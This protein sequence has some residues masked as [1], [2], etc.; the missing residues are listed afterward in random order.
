MRVHEYAK[1]FN[2]SSKEVLQ[3]L[4]E[5]NISVKSH[6]SVLGDDVILMLDKNFKNEQGSKIEDVNNTEK[7]TTNETDDLFKYDDYLEVN[8]PKIT[9]K[10]KGSNQK[11]IKN[12][13]SDRIAN[14]PVKEDAEA[15]IV[16]YSEDLTVGELAE[17]LGKSTGEIVKQLLMLGMMATVNQTLDRETVELVAEE[18]GFEVKDKIFTDVIEF[19]KIV[20][21]DS[22]EDLEK[23]PPVVTIMGHVDHGK[24]TLL[25]AIRNSRVV[26]GEAGGITQHIGAYQVNHNGNVI[27][28]LD[29]PGH[30]AFTSMRARGAQVTDICVLVVAADD[31]VMPQTKEAIDHA[32]A[33]GVPIIVAVNKMDKPTANPD[34]V[35]QE[36]TNFNLLAEEWGGDTI[37][38]RLSALQ[39]E[40]IDELLEMINL[41]S[42]MAELKANPKR[43]ATG[44]VIEAKLDKGR[45]PVATLLVENGTLRIGDSIVVGNTHGRVRAMVDD[46]NKRIEAAGPS[47]PVEITGLNDVPQAGDRFMVFPS[48]KE[49]RQIAEQRTANARELGNKAGKAVSLDDLFSQIQEGELKE[50]NLII[51]GDVQ[52]S[53]EALS[54]SLQKIDVEGAKIN[55]IRAS[56]GTITETDVTLASASG[57]I[58]IGFNVRPSAATRQQAAA[59][60]VDIRLHSIIYKVID[61]IEAAMKGLLDP[62]FEEKVTGQLEVRQTFKVSKVGTI[63]GCYV[64][65]GS[66]SRN[67]SVR[68]IRDGIVVFEGELG[69]L[70][71]FKDEVKEVNYGYECG[72]TIDRFNDIKEGDIIEAYVMEEVKR[73]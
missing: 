61:E 24:T 68:V 34:R 2:V 38:V 73:A 18:A 20:L 16:Y 72:I 50:L 55:I 39:G 19:E 30:A 46:L 41:V 66:V 22:E 10:K 70:K 14:V 21:E 8:R 5:N 48:E 51:K 3:V 54:G 11:K 62:V 31:G 1:Q 52:G 6:M 56:V 12:E 7:E 15:N 29:T 63:A 32:K 59:E 25:D 49:A 35:M 64:T 33:A 26:T 40:G 60:G 27:T 13:K 45:G 57:A 37:F 23:R 44:T 71:R 42:E 28:F 65:D 47:T 17:R 67:A 53:V 43:L 69:S 9:K 58:I 4:E 36:L